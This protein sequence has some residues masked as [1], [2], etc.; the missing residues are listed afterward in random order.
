MDPEFSGVDPEFFFQPF[1]TSTSFP[2]GKKHAT[3]FFPLEG[4]SRMDELLVEVCLEWTKSLGKFLRVSDIVVKNQQLVLRWY[5]IF[6]VKSV[7]YNEQFPPR[8]FPQM[9]VNNKGSS[10]I[11]SK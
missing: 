5:Y 10:C 1:L 2:P 7:N 8:G 11:S 3:F 4:C 9:V 6:H